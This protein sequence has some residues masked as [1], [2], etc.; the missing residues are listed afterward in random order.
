M[1]GNG[2]KEEQVESIEMS[3]TMNVKDGHFKVKFPFLIDS[4]ATY[5]FLRM[6]EKALD[7]HYAKNNESKIV[8]PSSRIKKMFER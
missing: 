4:V 7:Q 2:K 6:G 5:G 3:I 8:Q 1:D